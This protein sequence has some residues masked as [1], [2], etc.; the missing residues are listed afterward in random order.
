MD[1]L[2]AVNTQ[3]LAY[4]TNTPGG[5][6]AS[7]GVVPVTVDKASAKKTRTIRVQN[8]GPRAVDLTLAYEGIV[9]QP[10]VTYTVTPRV[11]RVPARGSSTATVTMTVRTKDLRHTIDPTMATDQLGVPR[12]FVSDASG[13]GTDQPGRQ[14]GPAGAGVRSGQAG[15]RHHRDGRQGR[16]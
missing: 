16:P 15:L 12:E 6:S 3:V 4:N 7:F 10:G 11:L 2:G 5:V 8:T 9:E 14:G 13:S 1:A